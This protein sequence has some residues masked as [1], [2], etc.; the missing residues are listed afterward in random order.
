MAM[1][2][3]HFTHGALCASLFHAIEFVQLEQSLLHHCRVSAKLSLQQ[4]ALHHARDRVGGRMKMI[5][6][7]DMTSTDRPSVLRREEV[8]KS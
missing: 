5:D 7:G 4:L 3:N 6:R 2:K 8:R 1:S